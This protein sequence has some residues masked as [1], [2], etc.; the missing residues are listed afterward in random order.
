MDFSLYFIDNIDPDGRSGAKCAT[1]GL[2]PKEHIFIQIFS[3][4]LQI[5][6]C[7]KLGQMGKGKLPDKMGEGSE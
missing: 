3:G 7:K 6:Y 1:N 5:V 2:Q 4:K